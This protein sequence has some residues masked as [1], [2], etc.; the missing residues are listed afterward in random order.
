MDHDPNRTRAAKHA[1]GYDQSYRDGHADGLARYTNPG[2]LSVANHFA[3][4]RGYTDAEHADAGNR[5]AAG[6]DFAGGADT[7]AGD[8][9][10]P[11]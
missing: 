7:Q 2:D 5:S 10:V 1:D 4:Q 3:Y 9:A 8:A 11:A 6:N